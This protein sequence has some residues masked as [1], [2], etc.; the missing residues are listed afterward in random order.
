MDIFESP[1]VDVDEATVVNDIEPDES[2]SA[3]P[4]VAAGVG[5]AGAVADDARVDAPHM[6]L[7]GVLRT[8]FCVLCWFMLAAAVVYLGVAGMNYALIS[9]A[10]IPEEL[11]GTK[12]L[13]I[14]SAVQAVLFAAAGVMGLVGIART[15]NQRYLRLAPCAPAVLAIAAEATQMFNM[16][17]H[18][19]DNRFIFGVNF[20]FGILAIL[21]VAL[22]AAGLYLF[23]KHDDGRMPRYGAI[24]TFDTDPVAVSQTPLPAASADVDPLHGSAQGLMQDAALDDE[25]EALPALG[26]MGASDVEPDVADEDAADEA[27]GGGYEDDDEEV[28]RP[29]D[30][31]RDPGRDAK[32]V[33]VVDVQE[34]VGHPS[35]ERPVQGLVDKDH[36]GVVEHDRP[37]DGEDADADGARPDE[38]GPPPPA[39]AAVLLASAQPC[40]PIPRRS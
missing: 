33:E 8:L 13:L 12:I 16:G 1:A 32:L 17:D 10:Q 15:D 39:R 35:D 2:G 4:A 40:T 21:A 34:G 22:A 26:G 36:E 18:I 37:D 28:A 29:H 3:A 9:A 11:R 6:A 14:Y 27:A 7:A 20:F 5:V 23:G 31:E 25:A 38:K 19:L 30:V 24:V